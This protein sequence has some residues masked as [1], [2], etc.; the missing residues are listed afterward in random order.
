MVNTKESII[1]LIDTD[2]VYEFL[3]LNNALIH[4]NKMGKSLSLQLGNNK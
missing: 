1:F 3:H 4:Y 2:I